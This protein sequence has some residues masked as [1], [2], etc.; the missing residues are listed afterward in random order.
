MISKKL[1][2]YWEDLETLH[3]NCEPPRAYFIP[4]SGKEDALNKSREHSDRFTL[5][6]G[7]WKFRYEPDVRF[8][9]ENFYE[10]V[11]YNDKLSN[12]PVLPGEKENR[13]LWS[14]VPVPSCWQLHGYDKPN[15]TN[16]NY[17]FSFDPPFV[18]DEN[19]TGLYMKSFTYNKKRPSKTF[20]AFE[21][22]SSAFYVWINKKFV[23]YSQVSHM[24]S[25]FDVTGFVEDGENTIAVM[26][27]KWCDGSYLEDQDMWRLS[28]IFRDVYLLERAKVHIKDFFIRAIPDFENA[29]EKL[30]GKIEGEIKF[31]E[32]PD[33]PLEILIEKDDRLIFEKKIV[34]PEIAENISVEINNPDIWSAEIPELYNFYMKYDGEVILQKLGFCISE[35]K[36]GILLINNR[37]VK[38]KG[39]NRHDSNPITGYA[40]NMED[41]IKDLQIMKLHNVNAVRTSHYPNDPRFLELCSELGFYV[42]DEADLECHG[43]G[44]AGDIHQLSQDPAFLKSYLD[45]M[46]R[47]V[48]RDKNQP[49]VLWWSLGNESGYGQNHIEMAKWAKSR[50]KTRLI[51][52][53]G[54]TGWGKNEVD[55][56]ILDLYSKMYPPISE[57]E[58]LVFNDKT[59][60]RPLLLCEYCHAMGNGPGDLKDYWNLMYSDDRFAGGF[61]WEWCDHALINYTENGES[62]YA[63]GGDFGDYPNDGNFCMDG[64]V[65]PNRKPHTGLLE[66]KNI[67]APVKFDYVDLHQGTF[68]ITNLFDFKD[69]SCF[70][71]KWRL[72]KNG[73]IVV[74]ESLGELPIEPGE[75]MN[76]QI[77]YMNFISGDGIY[78]INFCCQLSKS[79]SWAP[80]GTQMAFSQFVLPEPSFN[81]NPDLSSGKSHEPFKSIKEDNFIITF[82]TLKGHITFDKVNGT[83]SGIN[84]DG[85]DILK[86]IISYQIW[87][88]P[89]DN[90]MYISKEWMKHEFHNTAMKVYS[91]EIIKSDEFEYKAKTSFSLSGPIVK[92]VLKGE[93]E[94]VITPEGNIKINIKVNVREDVPH[95]PRIGL[96]L[97]INKTFDK[98]EY[99]GFGPNES[100]VD[101]HH[102]SRLG[103]F[104]SD[105]ENLFENYLMPQE[106]GS[107]F[108]TKYLIVSDENNRG[109]EITGDEDFSFNASE[110]T[111]EM[112]T[113]VRHPHELIKD[114]NIVLSLDYKMGGVGSNSCGPEL[115][116]EYRVSEKDMKFGFNIS[117][118]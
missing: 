34:N 42:M 8:V 46:E 40:V 18:P 47:M 97:N 70:E 41:M 98:I 73:D 107:R 3:V 91:C 16:V 50:D 35:V 65:Y 17:P 96:K 5:L 60:G 80:K 90:D 23:G 2:K 84:I 61:V 115:L 58:D 74:E 22:V 87:R 31:S 81:F 55:D 63:Y 53:E 57:M 9:D 76:V 1:T 114:D 116:P 69:L 37:P 59:G 6:S 72:E 66:L 48:E 12:E 52:Y 21:G 102:S 111:A 68:R 38:I 64:L 62:Y 75:S 19:P 105:V 71:I 44:S 13:P 93:I 101:K 117:I 95:L 99:F 25:E 83:L 32:N 4:F 113:K 15:Y 30:K 118:K 26:V 104:S 108:G 51:H 112:L 110:Y 67:I 79:E 43:V 7:N 54:G 100:Y 106:N 29:T 85:E 88:A 33:L 49:C 109:I 27:L 92:P 11:E 20:L 89:T 28:G 56:S 77:P 10:T 94:W 39:V 36:D 78:T 45:R 24:T 82:E 86:D 103:K 14:E